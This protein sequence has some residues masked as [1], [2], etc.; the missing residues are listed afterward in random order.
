MAKDTYSI[1]LSLNCY[2]LPPLK[3]IFSTQI[4]TKINA[5]MLDFIEQAYLMSDLNT[6]AEQHVVQ[7]EDEIPPPY[8]RYPS[9]TN[10]SVTKNTKRNLNAI[11]FLMVLSNAFFVSL[12]TIVVTAPNLFN[13]LLAWALFAT[14][15]IVCNF[16]TLF[17]SRQSNLKIL[18]ICTRIVVCCSLVFVTLVTMKY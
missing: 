14:H 9:L 1:F 3:P 18:T 16:G 12:F 11:K 17:S 6:P 2:K 4:L 8:E 5:I 10:S 7:I 15:E 13:L